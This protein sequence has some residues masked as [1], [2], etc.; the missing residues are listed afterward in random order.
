M[1]FKRLYS[2]ITYALLQFTHKTLVQILPSATIVIVLGL[3]SACLY[4]LSALSGGSEIMRLLRHFIL[5]VLAQTAINLAAAEFVVSEHAATA[6]RTECVAATTMLL[7]LVHACTH[8]TQ[9][10][11]LLDRTVT[12]LLYMYTDAFEAVLHSFVIGAAALVVTVLVFIMLSVASIHIRR[13]YGLSVIVRGVS[14]VCINVLLRTISSESWDIHTKAGS[15]CFF[16]FMNDFVVTLSTSFQEVRGYILW[17]TAQIVYADIIN[18]V[19]DVYGGMLL[20]I[21]LCVLRVTLPADKWSQSLST[22][23]QLAALVVVNMVLGPLG[24]ML[25][26]MKSVEN[27]L[28]AFNVII[29]VHTWIHGLLT[30]A[31]PAKK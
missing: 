30:Q 13:G 23:M 11:D 19:V 10:S 18:L 14:M 24:S 1:V 9:D 8:F 31:P 5:L 16:L 2:A 4:V 7:I 12:L 28:I 25:A 17:K 29:I 26:Q 20:G 27:V 6:L 3:V 22:S 21:I 15:L